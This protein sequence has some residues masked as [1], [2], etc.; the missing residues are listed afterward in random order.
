MQQKNRKLNIKKSKKIEID[1]I[2]KEREPLEAESVYAD[3][4]AEEDPMD[5]DMEYGEPAAMNKTTADFPLLSPEK[6]TDPRPSLPQFANHRRTA[7]FSNDM[8]SSQTRGTKESSFNNFKSSKR[9]IENTIYNPTQGLLSPTTQNYGSPTSKGRNQKELNYKNMGAYKLIGISQHFESKQ[10]DLKRSTVNEI[11]GIDMASNEIPSMA[12]QKMETQHQQKNL[13]KNALVK[14][15]KKSMSNSTSFSRDHFS[16]N[17][18]LTRM[19]SISQ[20]QPKQR[21]DSNLNFI[22]GKKRPNGSKLKKINQDLEGVE[23]DMVLK[24]K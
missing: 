12:D 10:F 22:S 18:S 7:F 23:S 6:L 16:N 20:R 15:Q 8:Q 19:P 2:S 11:R 1:D 14:Q 13:F 9:G 4:I 5:L 17:V 24:L 21:A 3:Q